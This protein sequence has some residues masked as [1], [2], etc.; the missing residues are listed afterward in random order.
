MSKS[1]HISVIDQIE[2]AVNE[3]RPRFGLGPTNKCPE[4]NALGVPLVAAADP[5]HPSIFAFLRDGRVCIGVEWVIAL[6]PLGEIGRRL[7]HSVH[8]R[9]YRTEMVNL[10]LG[11]AALLG[12]NLPNGTSCAGWDVET[13]NVYL[14]DSFAA[15]DEEMLHLNE[16]LESIIEHA[17]AI[18]HIFFAWE[19]LDLPDAPESPL[20]NG[21]D[22]P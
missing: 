19:N 9:Q 5:V 7:R 13:G 15:T 21:F 17:R 20:K 8:R 4:L 10:F 18:R 6:H 3:L 14:R 2:T 12:S 11:V 22:I 1:N 16:R